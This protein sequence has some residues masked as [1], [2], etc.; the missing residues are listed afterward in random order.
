METAGWVVR[1]VNPGPITRL[2]RTH[3]LNQGGQLDFL[4]NA[5]V[6]PSQEDAERV[7]GQLAREKPRFGWIIVPRARAR[8]G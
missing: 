4:D 8:D 2:K 3:F 5:Q 7:R 6:F 1:A